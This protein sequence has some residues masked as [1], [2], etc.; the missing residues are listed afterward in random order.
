MT[1]KEGGIDVGATLLSPCPR[2]S[3]T[4]TSPKN[5]PTGGESV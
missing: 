2:N 5:A 3:A 4:E 1:Q